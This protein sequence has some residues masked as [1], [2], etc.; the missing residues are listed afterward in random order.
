VT[1]WLTSRGVDRLQ[2]CVHPDHTASARVAQR[3]GL[4]RTSTL[5]DGEVLWEAV[6]SP[7]QQ[8]QESAR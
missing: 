4:T 5:I 3:L 2:A 7:L 6:I 1:T 8:C